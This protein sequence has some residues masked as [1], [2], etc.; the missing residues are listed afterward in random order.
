MLGWML[1]PQQRNRCFYP[2]IK[3]RKLGLIISQVF[4][5]PH[6]ANSL[7][8]GDTLDFLTDKKPVAKGGVQ[9]PGSGA[10]VGLLFLFCEYRSILCTIL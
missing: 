10:G 6:F 8:I 7:G 2:E 1:S 3:P 5:G 9:N 4:W